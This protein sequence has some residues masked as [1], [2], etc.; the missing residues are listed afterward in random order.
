[1]PIMP[2]FPPWK[3]FTNPEKRLFENA[4]KQKTGS[5]FVEK[6]YEFLKSERG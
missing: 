3:R 4:L 5:S 1:L 2:A 6:H